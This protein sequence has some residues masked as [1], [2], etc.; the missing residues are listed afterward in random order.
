MQR[1]CTWSVLV[2]VLLIS[3]P[4]QAEPAVLRLAAATSAE[5]SG[6]LKLILPLFEQERQCRVEVMA[7]GSGKALQLLRDGKAEAALTNAPAD[8]EKLVADGFATNRR[9]LMS[10]DFILLGPEAD[11]ARIRRNR[12]VA[13]SLK[14]IAAKS[15]P[16]LSR[17]D[18]SGA[19]KKE[20]ELWKQAAA[21]PA[22]EW[23]R[24]SGQSMEQTLLMAARDNA[25]VLSDR[26]S[27]LVVAKAHGLTLEI[28]VQGDARLSN[29]YSVM[30]GNPAQYPAND[31]ALASQFVEWITSPPI[32]DRIRT[33][34]TTGQIMFLP[35]VL[36]PN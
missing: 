3:A 20:L 33:Y 10:N 22:G 26:A 36:P 28:L 9:A 25:Y 14:Q 17:G 12:D 16:F 21:Q 32:Q 2:L 23:Y 18:D 35:A 34:K 30:T 8:E 6:L 29:A 24:A 7:V 5:S 31:Y 13:Q 15:A 4:A 11:P 27:W 19:H 1:F